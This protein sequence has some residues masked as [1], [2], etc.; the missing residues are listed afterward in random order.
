MRL[1]ANLTLI[2]ISVV[3]SFTSCQKE[4]NP[5]DPIDVNGNTPGSGTGNTNSITGEYN[6]AGL[7]SDT[8]SSVVVTSQGSELRAVT[9]SNYITKNNVGT[10][11]ITATNIMF[12]G[13]GYLIDTTANA[14][15]YL[16]GVLFDDSDVPFVLSYPPTNTSYPYTRIN[17]DSLN[18]TGPLGVSNPS[19]AIPIG[20]VGAKLRWSGDTLLIQIKSSVAQTIS[21]GGV[22]GALTG[23][24]NGILKLKKR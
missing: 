11:N 14:K 5:L 3:L 13:V 7:T 23:Y 9:V 2:V 16:D 19:G 20:T 22:P 1:T 8:Y 15:T 21:Q 18:L 12:T 10:V 17:L 6:F 4:I 24:A